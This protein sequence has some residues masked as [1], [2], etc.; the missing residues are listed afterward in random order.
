MLQACAVLLVQ[1][2][3]FQQKVKKEAGNADGQPDF[4]KNVEGGLR[5]WLKANICQRDVTDEYFASSVKRQCGFKSLC[6][7]VHA[8]HSHVL[9]STYRSLLR[10]LRS[11]DTTRTPID[12]RPPS[13]NNSVHFRVT[14]Q[15]SI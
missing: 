9:Y 8:K 15:E 6:L 12:A 3:V 5:T 1:P 7:Y 11:P 4:V 10:Q 2:T 13:R 14:Q